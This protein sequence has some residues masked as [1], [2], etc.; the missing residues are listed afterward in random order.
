M[1]LLWMEEVLHHLVYPIPEKV[2]WVSEVV[3]YFLHPPYDSTEQGAICFTRAGS[4]EG[5]IEVESGTQGMCIG[6]M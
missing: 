5:G 4:V 6:I 2:F 1:V 3:Q